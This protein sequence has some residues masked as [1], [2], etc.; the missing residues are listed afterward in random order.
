MLAESKPLGPPSLTASYLPPPDAF[1]EL[2]ALSERNEGNLLP[3]QVVEAARDH[4]S[5]L[6]KHFE[7]DDSVAA[8][9][10]RKNQARQLIQSYRIHVVDDRGDRQVRYWTNVVIADR[11][12]YRRTEEVLKVDALR[13]QRRLRIQRDLVRIAGELSTWDSFTEARNH[14]TEAID[15]LKA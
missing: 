2:N 5:P 1:D 11:H 8:E 4:V 3:E 9:A 13:E 15:A 12:A 10:W 14:V 7:W 6:H